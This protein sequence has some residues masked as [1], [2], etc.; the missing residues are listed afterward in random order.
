[1]IVRFEKV[2]DTHDFVQ[3]FKKFNDERN[4]IIRDMIIQDSHVK[5]IISTRDDDANYIKMPPEYRNVKFKILDR[6]KISYGVG[7][8]KGD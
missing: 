7:I 1:M 6:N 3:K 5:C 4:V 8:R 2:K